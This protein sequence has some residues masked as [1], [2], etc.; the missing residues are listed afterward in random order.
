MPAGVALF[1]A[2]EGTA[3]R[4]LGVGGAGLGA[5]GTLPSTFKPLLGAAV[6]AS[7]KLGA[8]SAGPRW[9]ANGHA[10][11]WQVGTPLILPRGTRGSVFLL[12]VTQLTLSRADSEA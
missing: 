4:S 11:P 10:Q 12:K 7:G 2:F 9:A 3:L 6:A 5:A 1:S 8:A